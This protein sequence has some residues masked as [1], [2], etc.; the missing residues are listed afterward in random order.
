[1]I[2][3]STSAMISHKYT[4][5]NH[6]LKRTSPPVYFQA[7]NMSIYS[8]LLALLISI[9]YCCSFD[10]KMPTGKY[11]QSEINNFNNADVLGLQRNRNTIIR[12]YDSEENSF[13]VVDGS[14][15]AHLD[16]QHLRIDAH[17]NYAQDC[18]EQFTRSLLTLDE[19]DSLPSNAIIKSAQIKL[20]G[21][22]SE[23]FEAYSSTDGSTATN[24][25]RLMS[26]QP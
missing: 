12:K 19:I 5:H 26:M 2:F 4:F 7:A 8:T 25:V 10:L 24:Q 15:T 22:R 6:I 11:C 16:W 1:M 18:G 20:F 17:S 21:Y 9:S 13:C 14:S 23:E 3:A